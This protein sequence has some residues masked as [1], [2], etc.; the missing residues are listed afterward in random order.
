MRLAVLCYKK[1]AAKGDTLGNYNLGICYFEGTGI[2]RDFK[3][4]RTLFERS[5]KAGH[6]D[7]AIYLSY[8]HERGLGV[9]K[10]FDSAKKILTK[11]KKKDKSGDIFCRLGELL[12]FS[13]HPQEAI[14]A[15]Q[16]AA[17]RGNGRSKLYLGIFYL[18]GIDLPRNYMEG[19]RL[20]KNGLVD[21]E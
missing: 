21:L 13:S 16:K 15:F 1:S 6:S 8:I 12:L 17:E 20:I 18:N 14:K 9:R 4:A 10:S 3:K 19:I 11:L 7:S 5:A 2:R